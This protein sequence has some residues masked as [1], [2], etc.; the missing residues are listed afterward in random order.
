MLCRGLVTLRVWS[1][2]WG[3]CDTEFRGGKGFSTKRRKSKSARFQDCYR[4]SLSLS[5]TLDCCCIQG[6]RTAAVEDF[7]VCVPKSLCSSNYQYLSSRVGQHLRSAG[8]NRNTVEMV[9]LKT[10]VVD[11]RYSRQGGFNHVT[12]VIEVTCLDQGE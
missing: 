3:Y 9:E 1:E 10:S 7:S 8:N 12:Y 11:N 5:T 6:G 4:F 2:S